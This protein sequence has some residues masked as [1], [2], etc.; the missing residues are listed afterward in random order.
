MNFSIGDRVKAYS[1]N[2]VYSGIIK[3]FRQDGNLFIEID[4]GGSLDFHPKQCRRIKE[5]PSL[6]EHLNRV[7][8]SFQRF[9]KLSK[10]DFMSEK[11]LLAQEELLKY[12]DKAEKRLR[13]PVKSK[14]S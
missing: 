5:D 2:T 9:Q 1:F 12:I 11:Y 13:R 10:E 3:E 4:G 14:K 7:V 6:F 8:N